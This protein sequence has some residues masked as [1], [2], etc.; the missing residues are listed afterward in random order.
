MAKK[1]FF[2]FEFTGLHK[3]TTP[4][5]F[6][7][8]AEDGRSFYA[9]FTDFDKFQIDPYVRQN[10]LPKRILQDFNVGTDY[11]PDSDEVLMK[12]DIDKIFTAVNKW[13]AVYK[14]EGVQM[15]GDLLPFDWVLFINIFGNGQA[16][17]KF[18]DVIPLDLC[19]A[20]KL[21]GEDPHTDRLIFAYGEDNLD[22]AKES[23][24]NA[25]FDAQTSLEVYKKLMSKMEAAKN[26]SLDSVEDE[27][28]EEAVK[29]EPKKAL[30]DSESTR[31]E[32]SDALDEQIEKYI[33]VEDTSNYPAKKK[34]GRPKKSTKKKE[35]PFVEPTQNDID[36]SEE[37]NP[38]I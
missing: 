37:F 23:Q 24:N 29:E 21:C 1:I 32:T 15:W 30:N 5:S 13:L 12:G 8:V 14:E 31:S 2:D 27:S 7:M 11:Q 6:A 26:E 17:P 28:E 20:L 36:S 25:L 18:I 35:A 33:P 3:L 22:K 4:I 19:T 9:E 34:R 38:P 10:V 16:L